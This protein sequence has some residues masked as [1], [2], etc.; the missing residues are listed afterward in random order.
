MRFTYYI[1]QITVIRNLFVIT[2]LFKSFFFFVKL[3][4]KMTSYYNTY[5]FQ[6]GLYE[7]I[8]SIVLILRQ[9]VYKD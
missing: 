4:F 5:K 2:K 3:K 7:I 8:Q 1:S 6:K 9:Y